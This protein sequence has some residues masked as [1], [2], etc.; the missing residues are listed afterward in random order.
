MGSIAVLV[1]LGGVAFVVAKVWEIRS[2]NAQTRA[3]AIAEDVAMLGDDAVPASIHPVIDP[4]RCMGSGACTSA[5]PEDDV[6]G[7]VDG[8]AQLI[9]P[10]A[11]IGHSA[12]AAACPVDAIHLV[13]GTARRGVEI[14][15]LDEN[16]Q[17]NQQGIY[18]AGEL[19]GMGL[20]RNAVEQGRQA[21]EH[22]LKSPR[23][24][25]DGAF[26]AIVVG[27]G[28][29]GISATL[30]LHLKG[31]NVLLL[32]RETFGGTIR[33]YPRAKVVM[34]GAMDI[35][36][37][38]KVRRGTMSKEQLVELWDGI[39][40]KHALPVLTDELVTAIPPTPNG[41]WK[42]R[43]N[44]GDRL[45]AN[46]I[47]ALGR[48][49]APRK[50]GVR[51]EHFPH[52]TY[53]LIEPDPFKKKQVLVVG[54]GNAAAETAIALGEAGI[55]NSVTISYRRAEFM[56]LRISVKERLAA[57]MAAGTVRAEMSS[58]VK[59]I[60]HKQVVLDRAGSMVNLPCDSIIIQIG[61]TSPTELLNSA[62]VATVVKRGEA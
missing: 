43:S 3:K 10:L 46:V 13:F 22:I 42:V 49:G 35:P 45:A 28:A 54:G 33:H 40:E 24:G 21:A 4:D 58:E 11:C 7:L 23:R 56:R 2:R 19:G 55:C 44:V 62:G 29:A 20:I 12:C 41:M 60:E 1:A 51:G 53:R 36:G 38:G 52:V 27:A 57:L 50:L 39:R 32:D 14:P 34:T 25:V 6:I 18:V 16:F 30:A 37:H 5:C 15:D 17:T 48:R 59:V 9:N 47:L 8:R 26:D 61:G 31:L